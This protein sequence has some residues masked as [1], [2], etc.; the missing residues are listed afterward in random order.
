RKNTDEGGVSNLHSASLTRSLAGP[1][2]PQA[3]YSK[4]GFFQRRF[5]LWGVEPERAG[6]ALIDNAAGLV[7]QIQ[8]VRPTGI[9]PFDSVIHAVDERRKPD[10]ERPNAALRN[11]ESFVLGA[12]TSENNAVANIALH[13]PDIARMRLLDVYRVERD[14]ILI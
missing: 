7:D 13:L 10:S 9:Q 6:V 2:R 5:Q 14:A 8:P 3:L 11:L 12:R 4:R 1:V